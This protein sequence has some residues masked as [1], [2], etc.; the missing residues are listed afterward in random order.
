MSEDLERVL[1]L[2]AGGV[3]DFDRLEADLLADERL[4]AE[5]SALWEFPVDA[6]APAPVF[7]PASHDYD[8]A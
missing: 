3:L 6:V 8:G 7:S 2:L 5:L 1:A 4:I